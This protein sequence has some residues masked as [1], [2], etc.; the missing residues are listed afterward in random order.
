MATSTFEKT[1][2]VKP[3]KVDEFVNE[4]SKSV[5]PTLNGSFHSKL[6][7]PAQEDELKD[8]LRKALSG[9]EK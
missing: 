9:Q 3:E 8:N 1:F 5:S 4:M 7:H 2:S 6:A